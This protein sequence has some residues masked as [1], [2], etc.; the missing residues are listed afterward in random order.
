[1]IETILATILLVQSVGPGY[2]PDSTNRYAPSPL[3]T[4]TNNKGS[5]AYVNLRTGAGENHSVIAKLPRKHGIEGMTSR[6]VAKDG[7]LWSKVVTVDGRTG[8]IRD[9]YICVNQL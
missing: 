7:F 6:K 8:W 2:D 5:N 1:M 3:I 4:C 9:D